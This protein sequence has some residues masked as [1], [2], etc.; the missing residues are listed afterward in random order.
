MIAALQKA[1]EDIAQGHGKTRNIDLHR[2]IAEAA[3]NG[4]AL[5]FHTMLRRIESEV[6]LN[7]D[8]QDSLHPAT[9][10]SEHRA[11][12]DAIAARA[13]EKAER[14]MRAHLSSVHRMLLGGLE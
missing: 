12:V 11:I 8:V 13:P 10:T 2:M 3:G 7:A 6:R 14:A 9:D 1:V 5:E 4:L